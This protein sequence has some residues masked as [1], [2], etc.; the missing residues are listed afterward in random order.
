MTHDHR[1]LPRRRMVALCCA[2]A[3]GG[4]LAGQAEEAAAG[5]PAAG[6]PA[7]LPAEAT[8]LL[9]ATWQG[10]DP[11]ALWD[12]HAHLLGTGDAGSGCRIHPHLQQW[13]H[14]V[15]SLR[16]RVIMSAAGVPA[17]AASVDRSYVARL[18]ALALDYPAGAR[19]LLYAFDDAHDDSGRAR[20]DWSTFHV[21][22]DYA[23]R[24]AAAD[25]QRF[26][27]VAS[28]HPYREDALAQLDRAIAE[29][30]LAI[31]WLPS[32]MNIDLRAVR[33]RPFYDRLAAT[34]LPL[35]VHGGEEK[36]VPGA[37]RD[38]FG[39]PLLVRAALECGVRVIVAHCASLGEAADLDTPSQ[40][41]RPA[42]DLLARLM[43]E[44]AW[45]GRLLGDV[46]ALFQANR[47]VAVWRR[48][49]ARDDWHPRLLHGSDYPLPGVGPLYQLGKLVRA[50]L[51]A[52]A[53]VPA[54]EALRARNP[55][56]FDLALK[57]RVRA[58]GAGLGAVVFDTRA[59]LAR[60][61]AVSTVSPSAT[62]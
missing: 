45:R 35:I 49:L 21:S 27:W 7:A 5:E 60:P 1:S 50:G 37:E 39:N 18:Q 52:E 44:P 24:V 4:W 17:D 42:F 43:D 32:A 55:L 22:N 61:T 29:G 36:A 14:P 2:A 31:K 40:S 3:L 57:R 54:L 62:V 12:A 19:W 30:A 46:S 9:E 11:R 25:P 28:V 20:P 47:R 38:A 34:G 56:L 53:D 59:H 16:R 6:P 51:L 15:E 41:P 58:D 8:D 23:A 13:W 48:V 33:V 10:L 26:A